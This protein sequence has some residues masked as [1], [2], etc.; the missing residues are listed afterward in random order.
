MKRLNALF[1]LCL[2]T[3]GCAFTQAELN[4]G[5]DPAKAERGP[6]SSVE[7]LKISIPE[8]KDSRMDTEVIGH[9]INGMGMETADIVTKEPVSEIMRTALI[10]MFEKNGHLL[11]G[12]GGQIVLDGEIKEFWLELQINMMTVEFMGT[13]ALR[14]KVK[15]ASQKVLYDKEYQGH[16]NEKKAAGYVKSWEKVMNITLEKLIYQIATDRELVEVLTAQVSQSGLESAAV[17]DIRSS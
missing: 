6:L 13:I 1:I 9:K 16:Y 5:Y 14:L 4:I 8:L 2:L 12:T 7:P 10:T 11:N 17:S 15:D 3:G